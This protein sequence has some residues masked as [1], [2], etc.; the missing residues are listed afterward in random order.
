MNLYNT[1]LA[2]TD[3]RKFHLLDKTK[4]KE[5]ISHQNEVYALFI[6]ID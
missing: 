1:T 3:R 2:I 4:R 5:L 6:Y